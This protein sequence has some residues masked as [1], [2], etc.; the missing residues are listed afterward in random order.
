MTML[1]KI[2]Y[3]YFKK[4]RILY[5]IVIMKK[6]LQKTAHNRNKL[7]INGSHDCLIDLYVIY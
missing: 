2:S 7:M 6:K 3:F 1:K 4:T 5:F